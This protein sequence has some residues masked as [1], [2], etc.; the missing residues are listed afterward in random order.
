MKKL[1]TLRNSSVTRG[2]LS[3]EHGVGYRKTSQRRADVAGHP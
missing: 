1:A 3:I 2:H